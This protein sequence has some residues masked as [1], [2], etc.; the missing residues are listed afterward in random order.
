MACTHVT[1]SWMVQRKLEPHE[2]KDVYGTQK[3]V[4]QFYKQSTKNNYHC[5]RFIQIYGLN[6]K[7]LKGVRSLV[8]K[9]EQLIIDG[10]DSTHSGIDSIYSSS[11]C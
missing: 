2:V 9:N 11:S 1:V 4:S 6:L 10:I 8:Y 5:I 3:R 7:C